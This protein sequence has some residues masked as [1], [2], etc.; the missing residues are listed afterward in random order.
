MPTVIINKFDGGQA[1]D[2]RTFSTDQ[3]TES[4]NFDIFT[5]PHRL[6]PYSDSIADTADVAIA[7]SEIS[8]VD[9]CEISGTEY[10]VGAGFT[11]SSSDVLS[12]YT[13]TTV[14]GAFALQASASGNAFVKGSLVTYK[15][16]AY[17]VDTN[18]SGTYRLVRFNG[19]SSV[20]NIGNISA[21][22]S[23]PVS[24]FVHPEDNVLYVVI[25]NVIA[26]WD[27]TT[28]STV[29]TILP[30]NYTSSSIT[31]YGG[32]LAITMNAQSGS[33]NPMCLLWGRDTTINTL[34]GSIDLGE[35]Y[36]GVVENINNNLFFIMSPYSSFSTNNQ[37]KIIVKGYAGGSVETVA[38]LNDNSTLSIGTVQ[39][40]KAKKDNRV[41]FGFGNSDC[42]W[43][44]GKNKDGR[45]AITQDRFITNGTQISS[46]PATGTFS[47]VSIIGD[48][49]WIGGISITNVYT[50]MRSRVVS[51]EGL[52][53]TSTSKYVTTVN[54][55]M[56]TEDRYKDKQ[57]EA[58]QVAFTAASPGATDST[59][60]LKYG[61]DGGSLTTAISSAQ[62]NGEYVVEATNDNDG[63]PFLS[64]RELTLQ[65]ESTQNAKIK[66]VRYK[67]K[68]LNTTI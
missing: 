35:G 26:K 2:V 66:E 3:C 25:E 48:V 51:G 9:V 60:V 32:Y 6:N 53:Y 56:L 4:N 54:P 23:K 18:G 42:V 31:N 29:S 68:V 8:D 61:F 20:S 57:L 39:T 64:G 46:N 7:D 67:Y 13:K 15:K 40:Y 44:F 27:G 49:M 11:S 21:A 14:T 5:E 24:C 38:E 1:D 16:L 52:L 65:L 30:L 33:R 19:A 47:G 34:Q 37:N 36:V 58:V 45:Y 12:F 17:A 59:V 28:F 63:E 50:L 55:S 10:I 43:T 62:E 41:Y 22:A